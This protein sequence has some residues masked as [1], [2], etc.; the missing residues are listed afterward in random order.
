MQPA[1]ILAAED[2]NKL[3]GLVNLVPELCKRVEALEAEKQQDNRLLSVKEAAKFL[4]AKEDTV[5]NYLNLDKNNPRHIPSRMTT[6]KSKGIAF[7]DLQKFVTRN[8]S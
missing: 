5:R 8:R 3:V 2:Y 4:G 1:V 7:A 6:G